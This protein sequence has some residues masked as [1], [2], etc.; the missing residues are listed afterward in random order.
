MTKID[1]KFNDFKIAI[2]AE[3]REQIKQ[4]VS[5]ALEKEIKKREELKSTVCMLQKHVKNYQKQVTEL[6]ASQDELEQYG[7]RLRSR[8]DGVPVAENE[9]SNDVLLNVKSIIEESSSEIPDV[10]IDRAHRIGKAYTD[11]KS[12][13]KCKN[14]IVRFK[15]FRLRTMFYHSRKNLKRNVK[16][17][18]DLTKKRYSIFTEAMQLVK[19]NDV[20]KFVMADSNCCLKVAFKDGNSFFLVIVIISI[21]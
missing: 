1:E 11:K 4:D 18:L 3:I 20:V 8:I 5:E 16:V 2:I 17:K 13:V 15:I 9:T 14:I 7:R 6:K 10:P 19:N 12:R 21:L